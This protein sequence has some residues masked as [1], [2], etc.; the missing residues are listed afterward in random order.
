MLL[1]LSSPALFLLC[2]VTLRFYFRV[3]SR[4]HGLL[5]FVL[6]CRAAGGPAMS[7]LPEAE[8]V[9][10]S[11][12]LYRYLLRCCRRLPPGHIQQHYRHAIRQ[13]RDAAARLGCSALRG[14]GFCCC[15][16]NQH[17]LRR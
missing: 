15:C 8:L 13:V 17:N 2:T 11:V 1:N 4:I 16:L 14:W 5:W 12:Q 3:V 9:R 7:P 6:C 10:S